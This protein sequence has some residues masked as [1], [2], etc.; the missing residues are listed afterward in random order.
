[1]QQIINDLWLLPRHIVSDA[2]DEALRRLNTY[3]PLT[4]HEVPSGTECWTW[5]IPN[6][7]QANE[8][9]IEAA[10]TGERLLDLADHPLHILYGSLPFDG[11]VS[12]DELFR[13]LRWQDDRPGAIPFDFKYYERDWGFC[14]PKNALSRF[15]AE[16]YRVKIDVV[17]EPG[18]LKIGEHFIQGQ[19]DRC[20]VI[21]SH[22]C[23]PAMVNDDLAGV[24]VSADVA[25]NLPASPYYSYRFL[26]LPETIGSV[27]YLSQHEPLIPTMAA[28]IFLEMLATSG[29]LALQHSY[30]H[31][32]RIDHAATYVL[33]K[34]QPDLQEGAFR[35]IIG[36]DEMVFDSPGVRIPM[37]SLSRWPYPE[38]HTSDDNPNVVVPE[39]LV[40]ARDAVLDLI[41]YLE[42]D[43]VPKRN[44]RGPLFLSGYGLWVDWRVNRKLNR[45]LEWVINNLEGDYSI[46]ELAAKADIDFWELKQW[47]DKALAQGVITKHPAL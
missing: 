29:P 3:L 6:K 22:L 5:R 36:N 7:W 19:T 38:Y 21:V 45:A 9:W 46:S 27:A 17:D 15:T 47:L 39:N 26:Y 18:A 42:A 11:T 30:E 34:H 8:A 44:F 25:R 32:A 20:V 40:H 24:A 43:Y 33:A 16:Q 28:G 37:I 23:H 14:L 2:Y 4:I 41:R 10:D 13:H 31:D 35:T 1:M 12:R